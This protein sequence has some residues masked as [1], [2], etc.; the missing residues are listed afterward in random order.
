MAPRRHTVC[1]LLGRALSSRFLAKTA[2]VTR[3]CDKICCTVGTCSWE[4]EPSTD[5]AHSGRHI[6]CAVVDGTRNVP[7]IS[8]LACVIILSL[9]ARP[10]EAIGKPGQACDPEQQ[11]N[12]MR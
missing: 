6:P 5:D 12:L 4:Y 10:A 9:H 1:T 3:R 8:F 7:A 11:L 2:S